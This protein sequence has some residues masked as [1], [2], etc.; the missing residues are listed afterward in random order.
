MNDD[1]LNTYNCTFESAPVK[2][3]QSYVYDWS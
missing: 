3:E 1:T 2:L